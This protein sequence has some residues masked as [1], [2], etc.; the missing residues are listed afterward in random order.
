M[1]Q[2]NCLAEP[3]ALQLGYSVTSQAPDHLFFS[4]SLG[5]CDPAPEPFITTSSSL[6]KKMGWKLM[7]HTDPRRTKR[8]VLLPVDSTQNSLGWR[9]SSPFFLFLLMI[10]QLPKRQV[11]SGIWRPRLPFSAGESGEEPSQLWSS[12][13]GKV[14]L[15]TARQPYCPICAILAPSFPQ[16]L[17]PRVL[18]DKLP[19]H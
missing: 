9:L 17:M 10:C 4:S 7:S 1:S 8:C 6:A 11:G 14:L 12:A 18:S 15:E 5:S 19:T 13:W 2:F 3:T 16:G